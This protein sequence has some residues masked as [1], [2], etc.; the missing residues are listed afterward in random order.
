M[1]QDNDMKYGEASLKVRERFSS[2]IKNDLNRSAT[3]SSI[4]FM[5]L[6]EIIPNWETY[7]TEKQLQSAKKYITTLNAYEVDYQLRLNAGTT[8][9]RLFGS[10]TSKGAI[11]RLEQ[12]YNALE[13]QGYFEEQKKKK[14]IQA[15]SQ[16]NNSKPKRKLSD[17]TIQSVKQLITLVVDNPDYEKHLTK[18]QIEKVEQFLRLRSFAKTAKQCNISQDSLKTALLGKNGVLE[19]L[20]SAYEKRL[21][22]AWEDL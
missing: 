4:K 5:K 12:V 13:N 17:K 8:H 15:Q 3:D 7:L 6:I 14:E 2:K 21:V 18:S 22:S 9:Q 16:V 10:K 11:G 20:K 1:H 19:K